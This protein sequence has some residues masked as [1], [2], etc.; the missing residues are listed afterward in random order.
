MS[1]SD[2]TVRESSDQVQTTSPINAAPYA[3]S[4]SPIHAKLKLLEQSNKSIQQANLEAELEQTACLM[5]HYCA[6]WKR[7]ERKVEEM[8]AECK[9]RIS[10]VCDFWK[11]KIYREGS[12]SGMI[13]KR[14]MQGRKPL[15]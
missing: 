13:L 11:D 5:R 4:K 1:Q 8:N 15:N 6:K 3:Q 2:D 10:L 14:A 9:R 7:E 12:R